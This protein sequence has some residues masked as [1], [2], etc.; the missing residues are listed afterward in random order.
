MWIAIKPFFK[1]RP[2]GFPVY[3]SGL[4]VLGIAVFLSGAGE[5]PL[6]FLKAAGIVAVALR[7]GERETYIAAGVLAL[8]Y[9]LGVLALGQMDEH[10]YLHAGR[11]AVDILLAWLCSGLNRRASSEAEERRRMEKSMRR[12]LIAEQRLTNLLNCAPDPFLV[13]D[14]FGHIIMANRSAEECFGAGEA[15]LAGKPL[16]NFLPGYPLLLRFD[17][18]QR[19]DLGMGSIYHGR[20]PDGGEFD[21][22]IRCSFLSGENEPY[23]VLVLRDVGARLR[24]EEKLR[25]LNNTLELRVLERTTAAELRSR[26][27]ARSNEELEQF[28]YVASHDLQE[29]IRSVK[30]FLQ[31]FLRRH[32]S[33]LGADALEFIR[34]A[35]DGAEQMHVLVSGLLDYSRCGSQPGAM[36]ACSLE[37]ALSQAV[38]NAAASVAESGALVTHDALPMVKGQPTQISAVFQN[39]ISN[40][41]K[42]RSLR[43]PRIHVSAK[44][45]GSLWCVCVRDNGIGFEPQHRERI[46]RIFQR[47]HNRRAYPGSGIGL[48]IC[49]KIVER[50][51]G[52]IF[53]ESEPGEGSSFYFT[54]PAP[55]E[56]A[57]GAQ[58]QP[59]E[60]PWAAAQGAH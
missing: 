6:L 48:A 27:L 56:P 15:Q 31:L 24:A 11:A 12:A 33:S 34:Y 29:P 4:L 47:L 58:R 30:S 57:G 38:G 52:S 43:P 17:G 9:L 14:T 26:E 41:I 13:V 54:L 10:P 8:G 35:V 23:S 42:F 50:H 60:L 37:E 59:R 2:A 44:R 53:A 32:G 39:L 3:L 22:E 5:S 20:R 49:K 1:A 36:Q 7:F 19:P 46:F 45:Q 51:Q 25:E 40:A 55:E 21:V 16:G 28:A 18:Q